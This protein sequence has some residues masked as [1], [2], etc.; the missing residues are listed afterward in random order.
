MTASS[1]DDKA[2][3]KFISYRSSEWGVTE[4][5]ALDRLRSDI[6]VIIHQDEELRTKINGMMNRNFIGLGTKIQE[7]VIQEIAYQLMKY[8]ARKLV[9]AYCDN[10]RRV[11]ALAVKIATRAG[12]GKMS[13]DIHQNASVAKQI[14]YKSNLTGRS[15]LSATDDEVLIDDKVYKLPTTEENDLWEYVRSKLTPEECLFMDFL[16][17]NVLNSKYGESYP[18]K[19]RKNAYTLNE[20]KI[21]RLSLQHKIERI[22]KERKENG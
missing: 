17:D 18:M 22:I 4:T 10:Y 21:M 1:I 5:A 13:K 7:D 9:E 14:V 16:F 11:F 6:V 8:P 15:H 2:F 19:L 12:F 20:Y 3:E